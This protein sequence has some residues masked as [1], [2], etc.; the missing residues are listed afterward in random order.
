MTEVDPQLLAA[1]EAGLM[2]ALPPEAFLTATPS[3][4]AAAAMAAASAWS[5]AATDAFTARML[6]ETMFDGMDVDRGVTIKLR[7]AAEL[8]AAM[9]QAY[10]TWLDTG[11]AENYLEQTIT[12]TASGE[13]YVVIVCRP[14]GK[15]PHALRRAA[16]DVLAKVR[17][18]VDEPDDAGEGVV[19]AIRELVSQDSGTRS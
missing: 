12:D 9:V 1:A 19:Q 7:L 10:K 4:Y 18:L 14:N 17:D 8:Q 2:H 16:E 3:E 11:E 5:D 15:T 13:R 6:E